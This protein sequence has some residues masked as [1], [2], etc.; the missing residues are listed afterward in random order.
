MGTCERGRSRRTGNPEDDS[1]TEECICS[2]EEWRQPSCVLRIGGYVDSLVV[3]L[4]CIAS[5][6]QEC[7]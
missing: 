2:Q 7:E 1:R 5:V 3:K 4:H 6:E